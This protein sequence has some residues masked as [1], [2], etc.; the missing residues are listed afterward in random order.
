MH[1]LDTVTLLEQYTQPARLPKIRTR[2]TTHRE[3][4][5]LSDDSQASAL[6]IYLS[7][8]FKIC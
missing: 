7:Q 1:A 8:V 4:Q 3:L 5:F 6:S 2:L